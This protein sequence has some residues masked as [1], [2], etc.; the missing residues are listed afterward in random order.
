MADNNVVAALC[1]L[2]HDFV[3]AQK[4]IQKE[5]AEGSSEENILYAKGNEA[6]RLF[7]TGQYSDALEQCKAIKASFA[8]TFGASHCDFINIE[9]C[10]ALCYARLKD[11]VSAER[12]FRELLKLMKNQNTSMSRQIAAD[13]VFVLSLLKRYDEACT[14]A[15]E[16]HSCCLDDVGYDHSEAFESIDLLVRTHCA[17]A[18]ILYVHDSLSEAQKYA[19][20]AM[21]W[22]VG[23]DHRKHYT[24]SL[25]PISL[26]AKTASLVFYKMNKCR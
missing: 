26:S 19:R 23:F 24:D 21:E 2:N 4:A 14:L 10:E 20:K 11:F 17:A 16:N 25:K 22:S 8:V 18:E 15:I 5:L 12:R 13:L 7:L 3:G 1:L 6:M 9:Y